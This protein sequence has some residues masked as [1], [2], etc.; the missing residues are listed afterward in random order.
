MKNISKITVVSLVVVSSAKA[1]DI[2]FTNFSNADATAVP[3]VI[4]NSGTPLAENSGFAAAGFFASANPTLADISLFQPFGT[5]PTLLS[6][7]LETDGFFDLGRSLSIPEGTTGDPVG[8]AIYV[9]IANGSTLNDSNLFAIV[10]AGQVVGTENSAG[11]GGN[12]IIIT[13][14]F[15]NETNLVGGELLTSVDTGLGLTFNE[16]ILLSPVPE[17]TTGLLAA[18]AGLGLLARRRR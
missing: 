13:D 3:I 12:S 11:Q 8:N 2:T 1:F 4:D 7:S 10:D 9:V 16:A 14:G 5:G 6:S 15:I 18:I 17:P